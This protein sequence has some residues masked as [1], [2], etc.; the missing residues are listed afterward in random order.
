MV[1]E[2][3]AAEPALSAGK[4]AASMKIYLIRHA[5]AVEGKDDAARALSKKGRGQIRAM[6]RF[7]RGNAALGTRDFWHSPLVRSFDTA[8]LLA[9]GLKVRG[10]FSLV[11]G[12]LHDDDPAVMAKKL[13]QL[14]QPVAVVGHEPHL[15]AL[16]SLLVA[17]RAQPPLFVL[18]KCAVLALEKDGRRWLVRWQ[19][20]PEVVE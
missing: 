18:K 16:A 12:L 8:R 9:R 4:R 13:N 1:V 15:S 11:A 5:H 7:L 6:A 3:P 20:S 17:G 2:G 10:T 14:R 19:V